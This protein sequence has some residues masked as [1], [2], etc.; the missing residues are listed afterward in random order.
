MKPT[1]S[2]SG[3]DCTL[4]SLLNGTRYLAVAGDG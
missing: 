4:L 3:I 1:I 2:S